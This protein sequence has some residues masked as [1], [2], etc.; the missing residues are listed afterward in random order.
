MP[1]PAPIRKARR[2]RPPKKPETW[3]WIGLAVVGL[4]AAA[5]SAVITYMLI[6]RR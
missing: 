3:K 1:E 5:A 2:K 6:T 4:I